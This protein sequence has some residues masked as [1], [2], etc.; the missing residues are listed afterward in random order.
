MA[1]DSA[2]APIGVERDPFFRPANGAFERNQ[3]VRHT[4]LTRMTAEEVREAE[5]ANRHTAGI[6]EHQCV[7]ELVAGEGTGELIRRPHHLGDW[8][9]MVNPVA[10]LWR[11]G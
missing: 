4:R 1:L 10:I 3:M 6:D 5:A 7:R 9:H 11:R 8:A 2:N